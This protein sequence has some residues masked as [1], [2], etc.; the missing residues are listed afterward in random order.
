M[1]GT[2]GSRRRTPVGIILVCVVLV[3]YGLFWLLTWGLAAMVGN[4]L[5]VALA[6]G[7]AV[8]VL[9]LAYFLYIGHR[10]AWVVTIA[11]IGGSTA[12][13][14]SLVARGEPEN[15]SNAV[16]GSILLLYLLSKHDFYR[17]THS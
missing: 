7:V 3:L 6:M 15:L 13:R 8:G 1:T 17:P 10:A 2:T 11:F 5:I 4:E 9:L 12:W 14:L 16:V